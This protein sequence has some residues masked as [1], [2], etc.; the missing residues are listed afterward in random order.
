MNTI[1]LQHLFK[2]ADL[3]NDT[4]LVEG[5]HGIGKSD[6][7]KT[8]AKDNGYFCQEL[9][10]SMMDTGDLIG[11]PRTR[12]VGTSTVTT[13]AEPDWFQRIT[14]EAFPQ[15]LSLDD[16]V[17]SDADFEE[18]LHKN[19]ANISSRV[20]LNTAYATFYGLP[21]DRLY[22]V[23]K[24]S[25]VYHAKAK[26]SVLFLDELN[27]SNLDVR[28]ATM[29]LILNK[30]L[31]THRLPYVDG[32]ST[33]IV[34][35]INPADAYQVDEMDPALLDRFIHAMLEADAKSWLTWA[36]N[37]GINQVVQDF[38]AENP[39]LIHWT[40][41]DEGIGATPRSWAKL[42]AFIDIIEKTPKEVHFTIIK[43]KI[44]SELAG[45]F[46][47]F[48]NNYSKVVKF[49]DVEA[50]I[51]KQAKKDKNPEV[52]AKAVAKLIKDQE[53]IQKSQLADTFYD[54]YIKG[55]DKADDAMPALAFLYALDIELRASLLKARKG[56]DTT[57][58]MKMASFD[59]E[60]N[61]R[62]LFRKITTKVID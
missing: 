29:Q 15:H 9:F 13:W 46:L 34:A 10:L 52:I 24:D 1:E 32:K 47:S 22:I 25:T 43:G 38:I 35:A 60:L 57:N 17:I 20:E 12:T 54:K 18:Y 37:S 56:D 21:D 58:Y 61:D 27:R 3:A 2:A 62:K 59:G 53:A 16:L 49:E 11:I 19:H 8:Y 48:Y 31:H 39:K 51:T 36:R 23:E 5:L 40:P 30:E 4:P 14:D 6:S 28:Q 55:K 41:K 50:L 33:M 44:G 7:V 26:R 42:A 45:Q